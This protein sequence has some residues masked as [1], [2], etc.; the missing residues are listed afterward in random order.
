MN[1]YG[2][3]ILKPLKSLHGEHSDKFGRNIAPRFKFGNP[4]M[5]LVVNVI[6]FKI[7]FTTDR[8]IR[9]LKVDDSE[10]ESESSSDDEDSNK[11]DDIDATIKD[12]KRIEENISTL[13]TSFFSGV[14]HDTE[15]T[16]ESAHHHVHQSRS[17]RGLVQLQTQLAIQSLLY[18]KRCPMHLVTIK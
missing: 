7:R 2:K 16:I 17:M 3:Q 13:A 1:S 6:S 4:A 14:E 18:Q 9:K 11:E 10:S 8:C 12:I 15:V 5:T